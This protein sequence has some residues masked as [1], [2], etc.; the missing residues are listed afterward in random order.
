[1]PFSD[2]FNRAELGSNYA[3]DGGNPNDPSSITIIDNEL[4]VPANAWG[5]LDLLI[6]SEPFP[7]IIEYD[8]WV[9]PDPADG[10]HGF[11][12]E[13]AALNVYGYIDN[14]ASAGHWVVYLGLDSAEF[15]VEPDTWYRVKFYHSNVVGAPY[16]FKVWDRNGAEPDDWLLETTST[17]SA[18]ITGHYI[19]MDAAGGNIYPT[20]IDNLEIYPAAADPIPTPQLITGRI[21]RSVSMSVL[22]RR[23]MAFSAFIPPV[24]PDEDDEPTGPGANGPRCLPQCAGVG[25]GGG[26]AGWGAQKLPLTRCTHQ[27]VYFRTDT[28]FLGRGSAGLESAEHCGWTSEH[29]RDSHVTKL[30]V[31]YPTLPAEDFRLRAKMTWDINGPDSMAVRVYNVPTFPTT[32]VDGCEDAGFFGE[33]NEGKHV[34]TFSFTND[35]EAMGIIIIGHQQVKYQETPATI[36]IDGAGLISNVFRFQLDDEN[37]YYKAKFR[38]ANA[39][40]PS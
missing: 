25:A 5:S 3:F 11:Q 2:N 21:H 7:T 12:V 28:E 33:W 9:P 30:W 38:A 23:P 19:Y 27:S 16:N 4:V 15:P 39:E 31:A 10:Y 24:T 26:L 29:Y 32:P 8:I 14:A 1:M 6:P 20:K 36:K 34:G 22:R 35:V 18:P 37:N 40:W 13:T 17:A